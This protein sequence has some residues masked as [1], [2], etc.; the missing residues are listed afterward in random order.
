MKAFDRLTAI[1]N[2]AL[3]VLTEGTNRIA[4][5]PDMGARVFVE[6]G[7]TFV[8]RI[9]WETVERPDRPFN[10][11]GG[12]NLWPAP[13]GG[14]FGFNYRGDEWMVQS[15][16][17]DE[18]FGIREMG[19][20]SVVL[21]KRSALTNRLGTCVEVDITREVAVVPPASCL[22]LF[23]PAAMVS[24]ETRDRMEVLNDVSSHEALIAAWNLEQFDATE[25]TMAFVRVA[26]PEGAVNEDYYEPSPV[27]LITPYSE[28]FTFQ[29]NGRQRGQ[30]GLRTSAGTERIGFY[31]LQRKL[32]CLKE[33]LG[34][35]EGIYFN[36]AD[37]SQPK[38]PYSAAD[39]YSIFNS[40]AEM[41]A[42]ELETIGALR[43]DGERLKESRL[44]SR[45]T[46]ALFQNADPIVQFLNRELGV[47]S[48]PLST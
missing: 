38:G 15:A 35:K 24:V 37:N 31:D 42:F 13:E 25:H 43:V 18:P 16:I 20:T 2:D 22:A 23:N 21:S 40:D 8:H 36:I 26:S 34:P 10:N 30:I 48:T 11:F 27:N 7:E 46:Y 41:Q 33:H 44:L 45:T 17:N 47:P 28:G 5:A 19:C 6:V 3:V 14:R 32:V 29:V 39:N 9:E 12:V 1:K 4:V